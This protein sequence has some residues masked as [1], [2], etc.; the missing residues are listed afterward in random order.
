MQMNILTKMQKNREVDLKRA[1]TPQTENAFDAVSE[2]DC[3]NGL[4]LCGGTA[5]ALQMYHRKSEDLDFELIG[6]SKNRPRLD[7][8]SIIGEVM[9]KFSGSRKEILSD[10]H[11]QIYLPTGVK[12][13]FFRPEFAVPHL[14]V[15]LVYNNIVTPNL[16]DLLGMKLYT[17]T[18]RNAFRD[19]YD[20]YCLLR[21][22]FSLK[23]G[24][25]YAG[26]FSRHSVH[27]KDILSM[28]TTSSF[29]PSKTEITRLDPVYR[30]SAEEMSEFIKDVIN[31]EYYENKEKQEIEIISE[32][33][34]GIKI[35]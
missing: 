22:G 20:I 28:L 19:Y 10:A 1:L 23:E 29:Y 5:Q 2:L 25:R 12:L 21:K 34:S 33:K 6:I 3:I 32:Q 17:I 27:T 4:Y 30:E 11:F 7:V 24:I 8:N 26:A 31:A 18:V 16:Q 35:R 14:S 13:S 9:S 15:G